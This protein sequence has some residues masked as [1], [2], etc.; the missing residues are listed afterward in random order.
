MS[1][2]RELLLAVAKS[3]PVEILKDYINQ[4]EEQVEDLRGLV[5]ELKVLL[6]AKEKAI[7]AKLDSGPRG[8]T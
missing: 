6:K 2:S 3:W 1:R 4:L 5:R 7:K 8:A